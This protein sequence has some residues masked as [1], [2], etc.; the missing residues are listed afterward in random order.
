MRKKNQKTRIKHDK[1]KFKRRRNKSL[2]VN[3]CP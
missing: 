2:L 3:Y 1:E